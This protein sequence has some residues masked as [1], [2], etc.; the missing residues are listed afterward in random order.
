MRLVIYSI[1]DFLVN[2]D[3]FINK[4]KKFFGAKTIIFISVC[5]GV[6]SK[7][8]G[9][10]IQK[11]FFPDLERLKAQND[12]LDAVERNDFIR[13]KQ[14]QVKF[15]G[16]TPLLGEQC[17]DSKLYMHLLDNYIECRASFIKWQILLSLSCYS[18]HI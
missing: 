4:P 11:D 6:A 13:I 10:I 14:L 9:K 16:R 18:S 2:Y 15:C 17:P 3:Q 8:L 5:F 12:Y 1:V 7:E